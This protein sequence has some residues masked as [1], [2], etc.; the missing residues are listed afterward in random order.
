MA[1]LNK[2]PKT[3]VN[4]VREENSSLS[5]D[6][7]Q[8]SRTS[9]AE[10]SS[11]DVSSAGKFELFCIFVC[12][13]G[14][15]IGFTATLSCVNYLTAIFD[16]KNVFLYLCCGIY[17]PTLP[18]VL[19]QLNCD[20]TLDRR[21]GSTRTYFWRVTLA[22]ISQ[23]ACA[24]YLPF[25]SGVDPD[26]QG[27]RSYLDLMIPVTIIGLETSI[28]HGIFFQLVSFIQFERK[29]AGAA[30]FTFGY[31]GS[32]FLSLAMT[33]ACGGIGT[34]PTEM[35][36]HLFFYSVAGVEVLGLI[37]FSLLAWKSLPYIQGVQRRDEEMKWLTFKERISKKK[38]RTP[39]T[40]QNL[41]ASGKQLLESSLLAEYSN[42]YSQHD[43]LSSGQF[44]AGEETR[45]ARSQSMISSYYTANEG[46]SDPAGN[47]AGDKIKVFSELVEIVGKMES[48]TKTFVFGRIWP[49]IFGLFINIFGSIFL[50]PF[51]AYIPGSSTLPQIL[52]F[53]KLFSDTFSRPLTMLI[54]KPKSK[55]WYL[56]MTFL[57]LAIFLPIFF[58]YIYNL[59]GIQNDFFIIAMV[60]LYSLTSGLFGTF[61][62]QLAPI[63]VEHQNAKLVAANQ[64]NL[65]FNTGCCIAL[66]ASFTIIH[67]VGFE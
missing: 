45:T 59:M 16:D 4:F 34:N 50:M 23:I 25:C 30:A 15:T 19:F 46:T 56:L 53:T 31:Q 5:E 44:T 52:F 33:F 21:W 14:V 38:K 64:M 62:Y 13:L 54:P 8:R 24:L 1:A 6:L 17:A 2:T 37:C 66:V 27:T 26:F 10:S 42:Q 58:L 51:Y 43:V 67:T 63:L 28:L 18:V 60:S 9:G 49:C 7:L 55:Y 65:S 12:A 36:I 48:A 20:Q 22:F 29:G 57:R 61:G 32:G 41:F 35:Q 11:F 40:V 47:G 39:N 3:G